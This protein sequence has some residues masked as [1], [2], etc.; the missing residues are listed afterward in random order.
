MIYNE[1]VE[2]EVKREV[3]KLIAMVSMYVSDLTNR[4]SW[5]YIDRHGHRLMD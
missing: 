5:K 1:N 2:H 4:A 3:A